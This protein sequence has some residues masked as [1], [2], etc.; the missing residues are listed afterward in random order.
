MA[1]RVGKDFTKNGTC[2]FSPYVDVDEMDKFIN[3][4]KKVPSLWIPGI[5]NRDHSDQDQLEED[6]DL[7]TKIRQ[8][9]RD[10]WDESNAL[11]AKCQ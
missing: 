3:A 8:A 1:A 7:S 6:V 2:L 10:T 5:S 9:N 4:L 11:A